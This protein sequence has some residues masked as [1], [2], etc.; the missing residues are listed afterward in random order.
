MIRNYL[1][2]A[3]RNMFRNKTNS[4][5][6]IAGLAI[7][8]ACVIMIA[9]YVQ[10]ERQ[11]DRS[12]K[13]AGRIF[14]VDLDAMMGGQGGLLT[15]SPPAVG[16]ALQKTFPEIEAFTR[17][18]VMGSEIVSNDEN[19]KV[20]NHF[21]EK[22]LLAVDSNFLQVF[23]YAM[24]EG[25]A[26]TCLQPAH[27]IV[28]T[29]TTA[30]K[31]FGNDKAIGKNLVLDEYKQPFTITAV[32]KDPPS[33]ATIQFDMLIPTAACPPVQRFSWSW[34]WLQMQTYVLFS[35]N[36]ATDKESIKRLE[37]KFPAMMQVQAASAFRRIGQPYDEFIRKGNKWNFF[38]QPLLDVHLY[39][40]NLNSQFLYTL[41]DIKNVYIFSAIAFFIIILA[42]VNFMNLSTAQSATRA[43]EIGVRKVLGSERRQ[44]IRQFLIEAILYSAIATV[45]ALALVAMLLPLF[46]SLSGKAL[47]FNRIFHSGICWMVL[48][49][50]M[51]TGLLAGSYPAFYLTSFNPVSVLKGGVF[52]KI[53]SNTLVRNGLVVFQF[54]VS[55]ALISC[56]IILFQQL[57]FSQN[58]E[59]GLR[60]DNVIIVPNAEKMNAG[61]EETLR[62][63]IAALPGVEHASMA[64]GLP[65]LKT[66]ADNYVP[67]AAGMQGALAKD[68]MINS[69][70][71]DEEFVPA[72]KIQ[73]LQGRNFSKD[74]SDSASVILN[75]TAVQ[76]IGWTDPIGKYMTYTG[77]N[78]QRFRVIGVVKDFDVVS[79][80]NAMMPFALFHYSSKTYSTGRSYL[81]VKAA[82]ERIA[83]LLSDIESRWKKTVPSV[84][85]E[86]SFL[87]ASF[88]ALY[89]DD[90]RTGNVFGVFTAL[91]IAVAC[92]G[93]FALS[94]Y[95]AERRKKEIGVRKVLG[96]SVGSV[97]QLLTKEFVKLVLVAAV[98]AYPIARWAMGK[99]LQDFVY[100]VEMQWWVFVLA[101]LVA[102]LIA[103]CTISFQAIEAAVA[104]P[105]KSLRT[106]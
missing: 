39:S 30:R 13:N 85:F 101:A 72:L 6:N 58:K 53:L 78:N 51:L 1:K 71:V 10:D 5:I 52:S 75:E 24:K 44:L 103:V 3:W 65:T 32:L 35:K 62:Q 99:W 43:K 8:L 18:Y 25:D 63:Q 57:R 7:G 88:S 73:L 9:L 80:R 27:A 93:L 16:P 97:V 31:Y 42:C 76:Q 38:L 40:A 19:S 26:K 70:M 45:V 33:Q 56:T 89:A 54:T 34:I 92:L 14:Q 100:R 84:P 104:N 36:A 87:D 91:S 90:Q 77:H 69:F 21:S 48:L 102:L 105:V 79:I 61:A 12:F 23:D 50:T 74:Y 98:I 106:E 2:T 15:N 96:A 66:F 41:G 55:I 22:K 11:F 67:E 64:S 37:A 20:Q 59:L 94:V 86:Y 83:G 17:F 81:A 68:I 47:D 95:T 4:V 82:P 60:K 49:L 28:L 29:E 46:N